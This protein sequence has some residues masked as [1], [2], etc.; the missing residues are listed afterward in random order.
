MMSTADD[1]DE[2]SVNHG[3]FITG[4]EQQGWRLH[5]ASLDRLVDFCAEEFGKAVASLMF[6]SLYYP[7]GLLFAHL[8]FIFHSSLGKIVTKM[9]VQKTRFNDQTFSSNILS[10]E[11]AFI[12]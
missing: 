10:E 12:V 3:D 11:H 4:D 6:I 8:L 2:D 5:A 9:F 7:S 1:Q